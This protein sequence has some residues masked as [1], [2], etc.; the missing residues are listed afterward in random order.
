MLDYYLTNLRRM[1]FAYVYGKFAN[2]E[3]KCIS[4][5]FYDATLYINPTQQ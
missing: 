2:Q 4:C 3:S 1:S 5:T